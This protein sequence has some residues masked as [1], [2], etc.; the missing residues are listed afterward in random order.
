MSAHHTASSPAVLTNAATPARPRRPARGVAR[1]LRV[2][3]RLPNSVP[4]GP[5]EA[6]LIWACLHDA[7]HTLA[8][9]A[10]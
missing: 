9:E 6:N 8:R 2:V 4:L 7:M 1:P 5:D 3:V 10:A